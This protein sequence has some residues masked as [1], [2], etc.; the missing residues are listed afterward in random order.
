[1][2]RDYVADVV[3]AGD[4]EYETF[5]AE[6]KACVRTCSEFPCFE[7]PPKTFFVNTHLLHACIEFVVVVFAL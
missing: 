5:E 7:I 3:H 2:E 4:E 1:V 6:P